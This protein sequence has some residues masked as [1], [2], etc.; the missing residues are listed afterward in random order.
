MKKY[1]AIFAGSVFVLLSHQ[2]AA[3]PQTPAPA[4]ASAETASESPADAKAPKPQLPSTLMFSIDE[5]N[6]IQSRIASD[7][8][9]E[10]EAGASDKIENATLYL[11]TILYYGP[12]DWTIWVNGKPIGPADEFP[13]FQVT[14]IGSRFVELLVPLSAQGM[15]PVRLEPNQTFIA[16]S[17][18]VVEG[19]WTR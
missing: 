4:A 13:E 17:G 10:G 2:S 8:A 9:E 14:D 18:A 7:E 15:R 3:Q 19:A 12:K 16:K 5:L 6:D 1:S 11:S